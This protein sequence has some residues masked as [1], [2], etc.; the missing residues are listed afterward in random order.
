MLIIQV[1]VAETVDVEIHLVVAAHP[2]SVNMD[3]GQLGQDVIHRGD[4]DLGP[5]PEDLFGYH[6]RGRMA[7]AHHGFMDGK[8]LARRLQAVPAELVEEILPGGHFLL[9][10]IC[11]SCSIIPAKIEFFLNFSKYEK[12][13]PRRT[14]FL[15]FG[16][17]YLL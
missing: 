16:I 2:A 9:G 14:G 11:H 15:P 5:G 7:E 13:R 4:C 6:I 17:S 1:H 3:V 8:P 12:S 10:R